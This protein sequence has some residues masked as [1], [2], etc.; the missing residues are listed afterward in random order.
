MKIEVYS[1][2]YFVFSSILFLFLAFFTK[3]RGYWIK[4]KQMKSRDI[5]IHKDTDDF[6]N[7]LKFEFQQVVMV[8]VSASITVYFYFF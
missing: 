5:W 1:F 7:Y 2:Y 3:Y 6:L 4:K 8:A